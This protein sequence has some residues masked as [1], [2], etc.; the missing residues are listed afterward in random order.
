M[1]G[2]IEAGSGDLVSLFTHPLPVIVICDMLGVPESDRAAFVSGSRVNGRL[3]DP[4][5]MT[6]DAIEESN[7]VIIAGYGRFGTIIGR[8]LRAN[9]IEATVLDLHAEKVYCTS[10]HIPTFARSEPTDMMRDWSTIVYD[11]EKDKYKASI[12]FGENVVPTYAWYNGTTRVQLPKQPVEL[13]GDG[14]G[15][16]CDTCPND[17]LN[18]ADSDTICGDVDN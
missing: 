1:D 2:F 4:S 3:I 6:P 8:L 15:D 5:P 9:G 7:R 17:P 12:T 10:C 11:D 16:V 18:D 13:D 14:L